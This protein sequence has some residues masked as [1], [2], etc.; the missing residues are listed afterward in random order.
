[1]K[2]SQYIKTAAMTGGL[3]MSLVMGATA[4]ENTLVR[5]NTTYGSFTIEL[6]DN[7]TP[8]TVANFLGYVDR[9]DFSRSF[10]HRSEPDFVIQ[11]GAYRWRGDCATGIDPAT[12]SVARITQQPIVPNEPGISNTEGTLAMAKQGGIPDSATSQWFVN[13]SDNS[14]NLD[15]QNGGFTAFGRVLG[16]GLAVLKPANEL[17]VLDVDRLGQ[18]PPIFDPNISTGVRELPVRGDLDITASPP[19]APAEANLVMMY[20][21]RVERHSE[22]LHVFEYR[23]AE[24]TTSIHAGELGNLSVNMRQISGGPEVIFELIPESVILLAN[25]PEGIGNYDVANGVV[26]LPTVELNNFGQVSQ[27]RNVV[28]RLDDPENMRFVVE[29]YEE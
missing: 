27:I 13:M 9:G 14:E 5:V 25:A 12:C 4:Q 11:G 15:N 10:F 19:P 21:N 26:T 6:F 1:M 22:S 23:Y 24:L 7:D 29:S 8:A 3:M 18:T 20:M 17:P 2:L 16:N 28:M